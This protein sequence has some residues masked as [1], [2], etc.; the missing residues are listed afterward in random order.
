VLDLLTDLMGKA[1]GRA[2]Y[3]EARWVALDSEELSVRSG[4]VDDV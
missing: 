4:Q 3:A 2:A 1:A